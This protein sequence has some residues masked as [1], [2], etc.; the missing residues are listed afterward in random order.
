MIARNRIY[1]REDNEFEELY[2]FAKTKLPGSC[3]TIHS[4][5]WSTEHVLVGSA[6]DECTAAAAAHA[7]YQMGI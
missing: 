3:A 5:D 7:R 1:K 6:L 4:F 2:K